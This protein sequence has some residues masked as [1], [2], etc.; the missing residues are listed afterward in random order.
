MTRRYFE[1]ELDQLHEDLISMGSMIESAIDKSMLALTTN[2]K[3]LAKQIVD[4]DNEIDDMEKVIETKCLRLLWNQQP[5]AK[6]LRAVSTAL[7]MITDMERVGDHASDIADIVIQFH[8]EDIALISPKIPLMA[9]C[10]SKMVRDS[11]LSFINGDLELAQKT[12][13]DD[14]IA[15]DLFDEIKLELIALVKEDSNKADIVIDTLMI[16]KYLE[17]IGDHAVNICEWVE[18]YQTGVRKHKKIF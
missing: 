18:F 10:V 1:K 5:V 11:I 3:E 8:A 12:R 2:N 13:D 9:D 6:D 16:I 17:R 14:D 7:K 15:D 4:D